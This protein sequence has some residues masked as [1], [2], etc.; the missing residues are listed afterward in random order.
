MGSRVAAFNTGGRRANLFPDWRSNPAAFFACL[1]IGLCSCAIVETFLG[2][3]L[4]A[5]GRLL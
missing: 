1:L 3:L 4:W 5:L 2:G